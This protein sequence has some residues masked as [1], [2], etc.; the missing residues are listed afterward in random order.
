MN[1]WCKLRKLERG[2][3]LPLQQCYELGRLWYEGRL[4]PD[5]R[6]RTLDEMESIFS[7]LGLIGPF[8]NLR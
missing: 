8:W 1:R 6:R 5:W 4:R 3:V 7:T 2:A